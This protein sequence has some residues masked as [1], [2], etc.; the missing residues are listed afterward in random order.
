MSL[1]QNIREEPNK[2]NI[3][4]HFAID[5]AAST[6]MPFNNKKTI[7]TITITMMEKIERFFHFFFSIAFIIIPPFLNVKN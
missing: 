3:T 2:I 5:L 1:A 4:L 7:E 6:E